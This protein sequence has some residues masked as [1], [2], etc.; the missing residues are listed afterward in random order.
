MYSWD[1]LGFAGDSPMREI[2]GGLKGIQGWGFNYRDSD[3]RVLLISA[4]G[5]GEVSLSTFASIE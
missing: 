4:S 3:W 2:V 1:D 5:N